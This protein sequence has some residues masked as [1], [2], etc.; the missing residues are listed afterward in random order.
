MAAAIAEN[1]NRPP[2]TITEA[3]NFLFNLCDQN[4]I[5][6]HLPDKL[7]PQT[8]AQAYAIQDALVQQICETDRGEIIGYK[9]ACTNTLAQDALNIKAPFFGCLISSTSRPSPA[10]IAAGQFAMRCVEAEFAFEMANDVPDSVEPY[11]LESKALCRRSAPGYRNRRH[12]L[13]RV[14]SSRSRSARG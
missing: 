13:Y 4:Q 5:E 2:F 11:T 9:I 3:A 1:R 7:R 14:D 12:P 8:L 10:S 6:T